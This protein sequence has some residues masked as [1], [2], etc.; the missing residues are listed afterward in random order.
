MDLVFH[1]HTHV[2]ESPGVIEAQMGSTVE[3]ASDFD[4]NVP[5]TLARSSAASGEFTLKVRFSEIHTQ[6]ELTFKVLFLIVNHLG[7]SVW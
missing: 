6:G 5:L 7:N 1:T 4:F 3:V 2:Y